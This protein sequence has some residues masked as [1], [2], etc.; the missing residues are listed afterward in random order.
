MTALVVASV[1]SFAEAQEQVSAINISGSIVVQSYDFFSNER[2]CEKHVIVK[3]TSQSGEVV[4]VELHPRP[5]HDNNRTFYRKFLAIDSGAVLV[6]PIL[7]S[8]GTGGIPFHAYFVGMAG[9][10]DSRDLS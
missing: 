7:G 9:I 3:T 1:L 5:S 4:R 8:S 2:D 10:S 6:E